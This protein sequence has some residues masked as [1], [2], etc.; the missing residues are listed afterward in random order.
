M[1]PKVMWC[2]GKRCWLQTFPDLGADKIT[3]GQ[4]GEAYIADKSISLPKLADYAIAYIQ[5]AQPTSTDPGH[6]GVLWYQESTAQLRMYNGNSWRP[7][8]FGRLSQD[9]LRWGGIL[10]AD[11]GLIVGVTEAGTTGGLKIG[12]SVP[13]ATDQLGGLYVVTSGW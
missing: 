10:D 4:F 13:E 3:S 2:Q 7:I 8:G 1:T 5:E 11:T 6:I 12:D 9:N